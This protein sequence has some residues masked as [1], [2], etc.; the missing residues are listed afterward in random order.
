MEIIVAMN[1]LKLVLDAKSTLGEGPSWDTEKKL[2]YWVDIVEKKIHIFDPRLCIDRVIYTGQLT[3][4]VVPRKSGGLVTALKN[5]FY[6]VNDKTGRLAFIAN[7]ESYL[8]NNRF[9]DGKCDPAGRFWAGTMN[10]NEKEA[11]GSLYSLDSGWCVRKVL[12]GIT[13]SNG[14]TWSPDYRTMY[15][16]DSPTKEVWAFDYDL[17]TG[18][19][20]NK[21]VVVRIPEGEGVPDGMTSDCEGALWVAQWDGWKVS[22]W[23]PYNGKKLMEV[24]V[25]AARVSS[26]VFGGENLNEL[27]ITTARF[28]ISVEGLLKQPLAGGIF[29]LKTNVRG[30]ETFKFA[31]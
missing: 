5:G 18:I 22:R 13:V 2:L 24:H 16:I 8:P 25:P 26:C 20:K 1:E 3:G 4:C 27:Y 30:L 10:L 11:T 29:K 14:L 21:R 31:G 9:N 17:Y 15:Y 12:G 7:P 23:N 28:G 6:F 19:I